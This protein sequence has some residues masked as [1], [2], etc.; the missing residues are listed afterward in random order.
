MTRSFGVA[1]LDHVVVR[2]RDQACSLEFY[3][4]LLGLA[5]ERRLEAIAASSP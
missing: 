2:C 5:E 3:P 1:E 4:R